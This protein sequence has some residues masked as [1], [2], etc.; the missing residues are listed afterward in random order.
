MSKRILP[1]ILAF[2]VGFSIHTVPVYA[3]EE[4]VPTVDSD[5]QS[6]WLQISPVNNRVTLSAGR[7]LDYN[8]TVENVGEEAVEYKVYAEPYSVVNEDY[9]ANFTSETP[10]TQISRWIKFYDASKDTYV[11]N[12]TLTVEKGGR[13][14][15]GYRINVPDDI[16]EGGQ[17]AAIFAEPLKGIVDEASGVRTIPRVGMIIYGSTNGD[18]V[19]SVDFLHHDFQSFITSGKLKANTRIE[20]TGNTD[21]QAKYNFNVYTIFGKNIYKSS[22]TYAILPETT[23]NIDTFWETTPQ[24]GIYFVDYTLSILDSDIAPQEVSK[25]VLIIPIFVIIIML[26]LL[27]FLI[28]WTIMLIRKRRQQKSKLIV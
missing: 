26:L 19:Q 8:F 2:F 15:L 12:V 17:Y 16:P 4:E 21:V 25:V 18:T 10:R 1:A 22:M 28:I 20:N 14:T 5:T 6:V 9:D 7:V 11:D 3:D 27:T 24:I 13:Q 23:R